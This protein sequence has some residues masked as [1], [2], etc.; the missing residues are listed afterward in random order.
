MGR[1]TVT[2]D[3]T[4]H[5]KNAR[6]AG[7]TKATPAGVSAPVIRGLTTAKGWLE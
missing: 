4:W 1:V 7:K 6:M 2:E 5:G 3:A